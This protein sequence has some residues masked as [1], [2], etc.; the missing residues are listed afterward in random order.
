MAVLRVP[1]AR[2]LTLLEVPSHFA[3]LRSLQLWW[4]PRPE[5]ALGALGAAPVI[6]ARQCTPSTCASL[7]HRA[8]RCRPS[9]TLLLDLAPD[10]EALWRAFEQKSCRYVIRSAEKLAWN[11]GVNDHIGGAMALIEDY[12]AR[13]GYT[14]SPSHRGWGSILDRADVFTA[15][16]EG[17]LLAA[18]IVLADRNRVRLLF[19]ATTE[20]GRKANNRLIGQAN[21]YLHWREILHY[22]EQGVR[23]YDFGGV[24]LNRKSPLYSIT[25]FKLSFGGRVVDEWSIYLARDRAL[26]TGLRV[27]SETRL[28]AKRAHAAGA[29]RPS[30]Q[31]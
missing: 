26:R 20:R 18:H 17:T 24:D 23:L 21:R 29:W 12:I 27:L 4:P 25:Q 28:A 6:Q 31:R 14:K 5:D 10:P 19:S 30:F 1:E 2:G 15:A 16:H 13:S 7:R 8:F 3:G 11:I 22:R 9:P